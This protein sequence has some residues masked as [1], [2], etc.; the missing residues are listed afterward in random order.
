LEELKMGVTTLAQVVLNGILLGGVYSLVAIGLSLILGI[1]KV[2][3]FAH[4]QLYMLGAFGMYYLLNQFGID[5]FAAVILVGMS[6]GLFALIL[7][8]F[9][10]PLRGQDIASMILGL[11]LLLLLEG[12]ALLIFG[13]REKYVTNIFPGTFQLYGVTIPKLRLIVTVISLLLVTGLF[14]FLQN[15]KQGQAMRAVAQDEDGAKLQGV[16]ITT[17]SR[18]SFGISGALAGMGG[19]LLVPLSFANPFIGSAMVIKAF[20]IIVIGGLGSIPGA[21]VAAFT[22]AFVESFTYTYSGSTANLIVFSIV[23]LV[24]LFRPRGLLGNG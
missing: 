17:V 7:E 23:I 11:G 21:V 24:L 14:L 2:I 15:T 5:Y 18:L 16:D 22:V 3:Q 12:I 4:G 1:M 6:V 9:Y 20:L 8:R 10:R 13:Q 19:A